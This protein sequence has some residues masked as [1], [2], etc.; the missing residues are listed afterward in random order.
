MT[1]GDGIMRGKYDNNLDT[2]EGGES[3]MN[4]DHD[5][6]WKD[7]EIVTPW[8]IRLRT[9]RDGDITLWVDEL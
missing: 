8:G 6:T 9:V 3:R 1:L 4:G 5:G 7:D 2:D